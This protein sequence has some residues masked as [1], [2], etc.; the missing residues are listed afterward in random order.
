MVA[1]E[2]SGYD[3]PLQ[4]SSFHSTAR[5]LRTS[6]LAQNVFAST[7]TLNPSR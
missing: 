3:L 6:R 1:N 4:P 2:Q 5:T 7:G